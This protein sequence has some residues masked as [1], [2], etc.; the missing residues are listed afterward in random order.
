MTARMFVAIRP[1]EDILDDL[2]RFAEPRRAADSTVRWTTPDS[3]HLTLAFAEAVPADA[4]EEFVDRLRAVADKHAPFDLQL[5]GAGS[6]PSPARA[7]VLWT[8]VAGQ[9]DQ[10]I[11][12][13][14]AVRRAASVA[15]IEVDGGRFRPHLT[16]A[17]MNRAQEATRWLRIFELFAGRPWRVTEFELIE[18]VLRAGRGNRYRT[19]E[20][21]PLRLPSLRA[22]TR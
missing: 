2:D 9:T 22:P 10:V 7:K 20:R 5:A 4:E 6:F 21:F 15:G 17:R 14:A 13:S 8:G 11:R 16:L 1:P 3:W 18:S 12:L 19:E